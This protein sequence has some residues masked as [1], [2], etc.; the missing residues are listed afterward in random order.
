M[1]PLRLSKI[2]VLSNK[3]KNNYKNYNS[4]DEVYTKLRSNI[5]IN[6]LL[7]SDNLLPREFV[8]LIFLIHLQNK[9]MNVDDIIRLL[10][11][12][13]ITFKIVYIDFENPSVECEGCYGSGENECGECYGTGKI[14]CRECDDLGEVDCE[15]CGGDGEDIDGGR[16]YECEGSGDA[17]CYECDGDGEINCNWCDGDGQYACENCDGTGEI[18]LYEH[19]EVYISEYVSINNKLRDRLIDL[20]DDSKIHEFYLDKISKDNMTFLCIETY[21][22]V[23]NYYGEFEEGD[24]VFKSIDENPRFF[25]S[26]GNLIKTI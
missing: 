1:D 5:F 19:Q 4:I 12:Y 8:Y 16:C 21:D 6:S 23:D 22:T 3:L 20:D 10:T 11:N 26:S 7:K 15:N 13:L 25:L 18:T 2:L 14:D 17:Q 24:Y 9:G